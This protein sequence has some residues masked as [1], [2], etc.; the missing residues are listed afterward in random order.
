M[1]TFEKAVIGVA[2]TDQ[3]LNKAQ[4]IAGLV[5]FGLVAVGG[6]G[7]FLYLNHSMKKANEQKAKLEADK[8]AAAEL[9]AKTA[10]AGDI[11]SPVV[12]TV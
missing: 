12:K 1:N 4:N 5:V 11:N 10:P 2:R 8:K 9:A 7:L 3:A 6:I